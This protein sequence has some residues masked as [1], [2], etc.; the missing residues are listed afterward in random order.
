MNDLLVVQE[1]KGLE[2]LDHDFAS[3]VE[4]QPFELLV[5]D[6]G[7]NVE[8]EQFSD[9]TD[10]IAE[11]E[12]ALDFDDVFYGFGVLLHQFEDADLELKLVV[13]I[14]AFFQNFQCVLFLLGIRSL[15]INHFQN[16]S[17][18]PR[19]QDFNDFETVGNMVANNGFVI[20]FLVSEIVLFFVFSKVCFMAD[21]VHV[22][23]VLDF[24]P[25]E[26]SQVHGIE[27]VPNDGLVIEFFDAE[28]REFLLDQFVQVTVDHLR[29]R[30][31]V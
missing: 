31:G 9:D 16:L 2:N 11:L 17:E 21:V 8:V 27:M 12:I 23:I 3:Y 5:L 19:P 22:F 25:L 30:V 18:G 1:K 7:V 24:I 13:K 4:R 14:I 10:V 29:V 28:R 15:M 20:V 6:K 26:F